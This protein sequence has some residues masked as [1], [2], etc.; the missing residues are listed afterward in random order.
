MDKPSWTEMQ[1]LNLNIDSEVTW[2]TPEPPDG[3]IMLYDIY[4]VNYNWP[5][6]STT[7]GQWDRIGGLTYTLTQFKYSR[8]GD[9]QGLPFNA[10]VVVRSWNS[11]SALRALEQEDNKR[12]PNFPISA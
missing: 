7:A 2:A 6:M 8:R 4:K 10:A 5:I 1:H 11:N 12:L 3:S 9:L